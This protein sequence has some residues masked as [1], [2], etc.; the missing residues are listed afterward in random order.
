MKPFQPSFIRPERTDE[1]QRGAERSGTERAR[2]DDHGRTLR[3]GE[4]VHYL[5]GQLAEQL[6]IIPQPLD[7]HSEIDLGPDAKHL[8]ALARDLADAG[9]DQWRFPADVRT[10][11]QDHVGAFDPGNRRVE[12]DRRHARAVVGQA[13]LPPFEQVG[14]LG[15]KQCLGGIHGLGVEQVAGD[16]SDLRS[17]LLQLL[18]EDL[19]R[20]LPARLAKLALFAQPRP[21][22]AVTDE[23]IDVV[24]GL[25]VDP[26]LVHVLVDPRQDAHHLA[27]ANVDADVRADRVHDVDS[28][29]A[30]QFPRT[31]LE[32]LRLLE[33]RPDRADVGEVARKLGRHRLFEVRGDLAVLAAVEHADLRSP[34]HFVGKADAA[35]ALDAAGHRGL[36]DRAHVLVVDRPLV[37]LEPR[38]RAAIGDRLVLQVALAA[39]VADRAVQRVVDEQELHHP[40]AG[41]LDH[42]AICADRLAIGGGQSATRLRL[43]RPGS[44]LDQAH[45][46]IAG[47]RQ[48]L[49][50]A[51]ARDLLAGKLARLQHGRA[52]RDLELDA[53][54]GDFRHYLAVS[55]AGASDSA[56]L[57]TR[58]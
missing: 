3:R 26:L 10:D 14:A 6:E 25:V 17:G 52:L 8:A 33:E 27:L 51:E 41:L 12:R 7:L 19:D 46:A 57:W 15:S 44:N 1:R 13:G 32:Q 9:G 56:G 24:A 36:D 38:A 40:F 53:V 4:C 48:P 21:V 34:G 37:L 39:L 47:D 50:V 18:C 20:L 30:L 31:L 23:R 45:A 35:R 55:A 58:W 22:E 29:H 16:R 42:R 43:G 2:S 5:L 28:G 11:Q 54:D 49:V